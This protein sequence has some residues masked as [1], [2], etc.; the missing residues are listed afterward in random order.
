MAMLIHY[1]VVNGQ[2]SSW[3][4]KLMSAFQWELSS[5]RLVESLSVKAIYAVDMA[6]RP[7]LCTV[8]YHSGTVVENSIFTRDMDTCVRFFLRLFYRV[9]VH[10]YVHD[11]ARDVFEVLTI[12]FISICVLWETMICQLVHTCRKLELFSAFI[13]GG[14]CCLSRS[15]LLPTTSEPMLSKTVCIDPEVTGT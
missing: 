4:S 1:V 15:V 13:F 10:V 2:E 11:S 9:W 6:S 14:R 8:F 3:F 7:H 5:L 12:F